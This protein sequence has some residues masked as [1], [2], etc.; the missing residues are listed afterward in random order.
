MRALSIL[1]L[2][3]VIAAGQTAPPSPYIAKGVCPFECCQYRDW[4][5]L[6][7]ITLY[8][9]PNGKA[10][11]ALKKGE[12]VK[13]LTGEVHSKPLRVVT[14]HEHPEAKIKPGETIYILHYT[15]E[16]FW[17]VWHNGRVVEVENF[18][19]EGP[20][21][22]ETWWVKLR[23]HAGIIGWAISD[24]NFGNQDSCA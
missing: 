24:R 21:P 6:Q 10:I 9:K 18:S 20:Y 11:G 16:G 5:A 22:K 15:G 8:D 19:E 12:I 17:S 2:L 4:T 13:A 23:T 1:A 7:A 14:A 3:A